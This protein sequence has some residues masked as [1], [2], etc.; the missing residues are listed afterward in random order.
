MS[1][2]LRLSELLSILHSEEKK[3][4]SSAEGWTQV[5]PKINPE[6]TWVTNTRI[7]YPRKQKN[8]F[9]SGYWF[10]FLK[11]IFSS[12]WTPWQMVLLESRKTSWMTFDV[13][14]V[15][16]GLSLNV[17][18]VERTFPPTHSNWISPLWLSLLTLLFSF[19]SLL[20]TWFVYLFFVFAEPVVKHLP[21][22]HHCSLFFLLLLLL[23]HKPN[24]SFKHL[25][26]LKP[27]LCSKHPVVS[28]LP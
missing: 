25:N 9:P 14:L 19:P 12:V 7:C 4:T 15:C 10:I 20:A 28:Q 27:S 13:Y 1:P 3:K 11:Y 17:T 26:W 8:V 18:F 2:N 23:P 16:S 22:H 6:R 5:R 24:W 21:A